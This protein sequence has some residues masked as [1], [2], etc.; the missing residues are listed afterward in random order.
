MIHVGQF[1][2][3]TDLKQVFG[4]VHGTTLEI[5]NKNKIFL[6][7]HISVERRLLGQIADALFDFQRRIQHIQAVHDD[8]AGGGRKITG[9][10]VHGRALSG[11]VRPQKTHDLP[12]THFKADV[13]HRA[14]CAVVFDQVFD[15]Y[16]KRFL[17]GSK[18]VNVLS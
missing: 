18:P 9:Q 13:I 10:N 15:F 14:V 3:L 6:H 4:A 11:A 8:P 12:G 5:I 2:H 17:S 1:D 7:G 16:H